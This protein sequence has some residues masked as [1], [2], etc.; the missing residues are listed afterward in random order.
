[1]NPMD[2]IDI[3][4][5]GYVTAS[6]N[7]GIVRFQAEPETMTKEAMKQAYEAYFKMRMNDPAFARYVHSLGYGVT[8]LHNMLFIFFE[9]GH[10]AS[11]DTLPPL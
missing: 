1:M 10:A 4:E 7:G 9:A 11:L 2:I 6:H 5:D 8:G 3:T